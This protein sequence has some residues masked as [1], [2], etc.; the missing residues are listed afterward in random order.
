LH[1]YALRAEQCWE[2]HCRDFDNM[3]LDSEKDI[4]TV[5][6]TKNRADCLTVKRNSGPAGY[7]ARVQTDR[8]PVIWKYLKS[9][10]NVDE[11]IKYEHVHLV[12]QA[13]HDKW[14]HKKAIWPLCWVTIGY[15]QRMEYLFYKDSIVQD[16]QETGVESSVWGHYHWRYRTYEFVKKDDAKNYADIV[17]RNHETYVWKDILFCFAYVDFLIHYDQKKWISFQQAM[18]RIQKVAPAMENVYEWSPGMFDN[19][20][21]EWVL[22]Y[23][24]AS[25]GA[26]ENWVY[27]AD[28]PRE[29]KE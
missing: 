12:G 22:K 10:W 3:P 6:W 27:D 23:Y 14:S 2:Y 13:I 21:R 5:F 4:T 29:I 9:N 1:I 19:I 24:P 28:K 17:G 11:K 15:G 26:D 20:F 8:N 7:V 16:Y 25:Q 18:R